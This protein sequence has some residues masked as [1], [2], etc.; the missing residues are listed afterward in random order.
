MAQEPAH[1]PLAGQVAVVTGSAQGIGQAIAVRLAQAGA[2]VVGADLVED[3]QT[4]ALV[5]QAGVRWLSHRLDV[6]HGSDIDRLA[7]AIESECGRLDILVNNAGID[8]AIRFDELTPERWHQVLAVNLDGPFRLIKALVPLMRRNQY[9]RIVN[10]ASGSVVNPM[11]GFIAYRASKMGL[12]GMT[13]AVAID[14]G[15]DGI[16]ANVVSPGVTATPMVQGSLTPEFLEMTIG[17]QGVKRSGEPVDIA[18][19]VNYIASPEAGF[20]TGQTLMVNGG[21]AFS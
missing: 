8:D 13:R 11:P 4:G 15:P 14:L 5:A 17:K 7:A 10:I 1:R 9:G 21:A 19:A 20:I 3:D 12:I 16:T 6:S 2:D 18:N